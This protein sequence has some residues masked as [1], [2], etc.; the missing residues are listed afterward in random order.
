MQAGEREREPQLPLSLGRPT[1]WELIEL[2][3]K[4]HLSLGESEASGLLEAVEDLG[5]IPPI[6]MAPGSVSGRDAGR[7]PS[8][9]ENPW[10]AFIRICDVHGLAEG[11]LLGERVGVKD[12]IDVAGVPTT[13][14][15]AST[16]YLPRSDAVVVERVLAAGGR[17]VGKLNMDNFGAGA[18]GETSA[19]GPPLNPRDASR[20]A[21]GSSGGAGAALAAGA[22]DLALGV[23]QAGSARIPASFCG[24]VAIKATHGLVPTQ[25]VT[26]LDHTIDFV[27]PM[28]RTVSD[29]AR[30]LEAVAGDDWRDPQWVRGPVPARWRSSGLEDVAG[31]RVAVVRESVDRRICS[32]DVVR[33]VYRV[34]DALRGAGAEI[35]E[36][37][38]PLWPKGLPIAQT[39]L[40]H[41]VGA[42][43]RSEGVGYGHLG[44]VD[45][46]R[47]RSFAEVRRT[48]SEL[49]PA[50]MKVWMLVERYL[51]D[52]YL[53]VTYGTI[54]NLRLRFRTEIEQAFAGAELLLTPTTP[55]SAPPLLGADQDVTAGVAGRILK[56]LPYN[57]APFNLSGHPVVALPSG[58]DRVG[59]PTSVQLAAGHFADDLA[60]RAARVVESA[61]SS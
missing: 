28:A 2:G 35:K 60:V 26:H 37:S 21:G 42:M 8:S 13:N 36:V 59:L 1:A 38:V 32:E 30:L 55:E 17:V 47:M 14:A 24:V 43:V 25:G 46:E 27:C 48:Q 10:N 23:D 50:Y 61:L 52:E 22:V 15:S 51:H 33:N 5:A 58:K 19:F 57:T 49:L 20:S 3:A 56:S 11:P 54:H 44:L 29:A 34:A 39:L 16:P 40:C 7:V 6:E 4:E 9:E 53:N 12:N 45:V 31:L 41:L 18:S